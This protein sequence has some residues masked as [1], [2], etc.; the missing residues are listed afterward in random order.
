MTLTALRQATN[1]AVNFTGYQKLKEMLLKYQDLE[2]LPSYQHLLAGGL[3]GAL[4]PMSNAPI[5]TVK[6]RIQRSAA[7]P[8][9]NGWTR[10][11]RVTSTI[12]REEGW[13]AFYKGL[14]PR[15]LRVAPGQAITFMVYERIQ[16]WLEG[17]KL[18]QEK[19]PSQYDYS[20]DIDDDA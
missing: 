3:S 11:M 12:L 8:G 10:F 14:T 5:D 1:Q 6:T 2:A 19:L 13:R 7:K 17:L 18:S 15:L 9:E 20:E 4:G 16:S